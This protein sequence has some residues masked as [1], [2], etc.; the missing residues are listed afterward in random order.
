MGIFSFVAV[1]GNVLGVLA[2]G[3]LIEAFGR[4]SIYAINLPIGIAVLMFTCL[5]LERDPAPQHQPLDAAGAG[6]ITASVA[7]PASSASRM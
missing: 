3:I 7:V 2:G 4:P 1:G 5:L 6:T